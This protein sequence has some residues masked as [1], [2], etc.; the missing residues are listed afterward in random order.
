MIKNADHLLTTN[1]PMKA[2]CSKGLMDS[3]LLAAHT[4]FNGKVKFHPPYAKAKGL[5][6]CK[7]FY[8]CINPS[9][10]Q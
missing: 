3:F 9:G 7:S 2:K 10:N 6:L 1:E 5:T 4:N 8:Y